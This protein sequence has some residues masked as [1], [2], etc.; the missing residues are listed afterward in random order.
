MGAYVPNCIKG[1]RKKENGGGPSG[2]WNK[3]RSGW[4]RPWGYETALRHGERRLLPWQYKGE[5]KI[6]KKKTGSKL[7]GKSK[8]SRKWSPRSRGGCVPGGGLKKKIELGT[9]T[10]KKLHRTPK[11]EGSTIRLDQLRQP[12]WDER[13]RANHAKKETKQ[14]KNL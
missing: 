9:G 6:R 4:G 2:Q 14:E 3:K 5:E 12:F 7:W 11:I 13:N 1:S 8:E 10:E